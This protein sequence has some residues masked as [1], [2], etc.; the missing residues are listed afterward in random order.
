[1]SKLNISVAVIVLATAL[2]AG[3][4]AAAEAAGDTVEVVT[5]EV[6]TEAAGIFTVVAISAVGT[7]EVACISVAGATSVADRLPDRVFAAIV[8]SRSTPDQTPFGH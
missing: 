5:V 1:M 6:V 7:S 4:Y 2:S 8:R 3:G